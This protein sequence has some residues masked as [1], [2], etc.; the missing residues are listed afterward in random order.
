MNARTAMT[1]TMVTITMAMITM[2]T[3]T[4]PVGAMATTIKGMT[5][6]TAIAMVPGTHTPATPASAA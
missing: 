3:I 6:G 5:T 2:A 1:M 4:G